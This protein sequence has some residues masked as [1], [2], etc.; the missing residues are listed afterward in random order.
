MSVRSE[1]LIADAEMIDQAGAAISSATGDPSWHQF[2]NTGF[3][4]FVILHFVL[5][6]VWLEETDWPEQRADE[7]SLFAA[8]LAATVSVLWTGDVGSLLGI[9]LYLWFVF[10]SANRAALDEEASWNI[11]PPPRLH[12]VLLAPLRRAVRR[13]RTTRRT[14][15]QKEN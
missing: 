6:Q 14:T 3:A 1:P 5:K 15:T 12:T 7:A 11:A 4:L 9:G 10:I 8:S 2:M 13:L